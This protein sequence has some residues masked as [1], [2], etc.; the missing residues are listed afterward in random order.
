MQ[1]NKLRNK[2]GK[3]NPGK[4]RTLYAITATKRDAL[5]KIV[6][7]QEGPRRVRD[8]SSSRDDRETHLITLI[9][10]LKH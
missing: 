5:N 4:R 6:T 3:K 2:S 9:K 7:H 8:Q 1:G 10:L